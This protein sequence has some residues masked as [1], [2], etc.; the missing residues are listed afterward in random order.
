MVRFSMIISVFRSDLMEFVSVTAALSSE[1]SLDT[2]IE[3][4]FFHLTLQIL[5]LNRAG[6]SGVGVQCNLYHACCQILAR[7]CE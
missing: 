3:S 4:I 2:P 7:L 6:G 1:K 5:S